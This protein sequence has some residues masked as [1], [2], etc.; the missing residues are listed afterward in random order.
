MLK[1][2]MGTDQTEGPT[3]AKK[4]ETTMS[5]IT[6]LLNAENAA[7]NVSVFVK[8]ATVTAR[9]AQAPVGKGSS[10]SPAQCG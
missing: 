9:K 6:S 3:A 5:Q 7:W 2:Q 4:N 10:T 1:Q 8:T